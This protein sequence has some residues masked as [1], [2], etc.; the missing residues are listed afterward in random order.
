[1]FR[2]R[3]DCIPSLTVEHFDNASST[4]RCLRIVVGP[5]SL[6]RRRGEVQLGRKLWPA[7]NCRL[8]CTS[9]EKGRSTS[10]PSFVVAIDWGARFVLPR[11]LGERRDANALSAPPLLAGAGTI[12][13]ALLVAID[14]LLD[15][16]KFLEGAWLLVAR[17]LVSPIGCGEDASN[18]GRVA[19]GP[20]SG[21]LTL[22][23]A[24]AASA[25]TTGG[26][27]VP[28]T[29]GPYSKVSLSY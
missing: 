17:P 11:L 28:A 19:A 20:A 2:F 26:G 22:N 16:L 6:R 25:G 24:A 3:F 9:G 8:R 4:G 29:A 13:S 23:S 18:G 15:G 14:E 27:G 12:V 21:R 5:T 1:M 7:I 10:R